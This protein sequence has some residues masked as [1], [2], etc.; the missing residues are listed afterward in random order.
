MQK[1]F[2]SHVRKILHAELCDVWTWELASP[3]LRV[4]TSRANLI[5]STKLACDLFSGNVTFHDVD[6]VTCVKYVL[7][8]WLLILLIPQLVIFLNSCRSITEMQLWQY[9]N[10]TLSILIIDQLQPR[11]FI[12]NRDYYRQL[13]SLAYCVCLVKLACKIQNLSWIWEPFTK[14][15]CPL[16]S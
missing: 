2:V 10:F 13:I 3:L 4:V 12:I 11:N 1:I 14:K 16:L 9:I 7:Q 15:Y 8:N 6:A 5:S